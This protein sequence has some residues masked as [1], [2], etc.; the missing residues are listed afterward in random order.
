[1]SSAFAAYRNDYLEH[2]G[3]PIH[4]QL[5]PALHRPDSATTTFDNVWEAIEDYVVLYAIASNPHTG[6]QIVEIAEDKRDPDRPMRFGFSIPTP[7]LQQ[8]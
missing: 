7:S 6:I 3:R 4:P 8:S 2:R 1:M 5:I